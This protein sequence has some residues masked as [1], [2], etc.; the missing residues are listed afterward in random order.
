[1]AE[2]IRKLDLDF[3][4]DL[5]GPGGGKGDALSYRPAKIQINWIAHP[6]TCGTPGLDYIV[7]DPVVSPVENSSAW[8]TEK[9]AYINGTYF[10]ADYQE[11]YPHLKEELRIIT[12][13]NEHLYL[14]KFF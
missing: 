9:R 3:L 14:I 2:A 6:G 5:I 12:E 1:M 11:Q 4:V 7:V 8:Y 13:V 10:N